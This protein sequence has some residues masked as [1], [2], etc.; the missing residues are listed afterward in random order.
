MIFGNIHKHDRVWWWSIIS[1]CQTLLV[2]LDI[3]FKMKMLKRVLWT[4]S[5]YC[6]NIV[7]F[8]SG[9]LKSMQLNLRY[10]F[11]SSKSAIYITHNVI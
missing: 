6:F 2:S 3:H 8:N 5:L 4:L 1:G 11:S 10:S 7:G 9:E